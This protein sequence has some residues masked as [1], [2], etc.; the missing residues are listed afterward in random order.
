MYSDMIFIVVSQNYGQKCSVAKLKT[1]PRDLCA[2]YH[3]IVNK[4]LPVCKSKIITLKFHLLHRLIENISS[5]ESLAAL[6]VSPYQQYSTSV[7]AA[8]IHTSTRSAT[9]VDDIVLGLDQKKN[10]AF[11]ETSCKRYD[12]SRGDYKKKA[13]R[14]ENKPKL[15]GSIVVFH[16]SWV[17]RV[18]T[19]IEA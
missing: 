2:L 19:F 12:L 17:H 14:V 10:Y 15:F 8:Y 13:L 3:K 1:L 18:W 11:W 6:D 4:F 9:R 5:F 16:K 7:K